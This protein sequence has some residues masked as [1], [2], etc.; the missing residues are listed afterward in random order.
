M[1]MSG[2]HVEKKLILIALIIVCHKLISMFVLCV[3]RDNI[4]VASV[5]VSVNERGGAFLLLTFSKG[6][7]SSV[8]LCL[9]VLVEGVRLVCT[10]VSVKVRNLFS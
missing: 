8:F 4:A 2:Q 10:S 9:S 7:V 1:N 3:G 6:G 5:S